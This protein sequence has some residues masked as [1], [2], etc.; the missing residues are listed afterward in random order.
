MAVHVTSDSVLRASVNDC[1][2]VYVIINYWVYTRNLAISSGFD[3]KC[4]IP[5]SESPGKPGTLAAGRPG[6]VPWLLQDGHVETGK[7]S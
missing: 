3:S 5:G 7:M 1:N 4:F 6:F 2:P